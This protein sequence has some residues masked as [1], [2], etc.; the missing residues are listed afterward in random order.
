[1]EVWQSSVSRNPTLPLCLW[2]WECPTDK[3]IAWPISWYWCL[4]NK[5]F[6]MFLNQTLNFFLLA[7]VSRAS[8]RPEMSGF[9]V[10]QRICHHCKHSQG[11]C[12][13]C[14]LQPILPVLLSGLR[15]EIYWTCSCRPWF[16][17]QSESKVL[18]T[19]NQHLLYAHCCKCISCIRP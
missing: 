4:E 12:F 6:T 14:I 8:Q 19:V 17:F 16:R 9:T 3:S 11:I 15:W 2:P 18:D 5:S 10:Q 7:N 1:M 13:F